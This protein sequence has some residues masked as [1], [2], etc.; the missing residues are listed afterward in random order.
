[1]IFLLLVF[2][3]WFLSML[4]WAV[5]VRHGRRDHGYDWDYWP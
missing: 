3:L 1:M 5:T 4:W 2:A